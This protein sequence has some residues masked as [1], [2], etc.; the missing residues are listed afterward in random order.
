MQCP[1]KFSFLVRPTWLQRD[2][3]CWNCIIFFTDLH[4]AID[5]SICHNYLFSAIFY[6]CRLP[7][8]H[9]AYLNIFV[10]FC[11]SLEYLDRLRADRLAN[12]QLWIE[13]S[14]LWFRCQMLGMK[15]DIGSNFNWEPIRCLTFFG[16]FFWCFQIKVKLVK[17]GVITLKTKINALK[18]RIPGRWKMSSA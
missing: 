1:G 6:L 2:A 15:I 18:L 13:M 14:S 7:V 4:S 5:I 16:V 11:Q 17:A 12:Q 9:L 8:E 3:S 10:I